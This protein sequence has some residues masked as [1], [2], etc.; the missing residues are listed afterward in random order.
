MTTSNPATR[1]NP[2]RP[3]GSNARER[4]GKRNGLGQ[5]AVRDHQRGRALGQQRRHGTAGSA[6]R[7]QH[8]HAL[9][10]D[11][12]AKVE[13]DV[14]QQADPVEIVRLDPVALEPQAIDGAGL[15]RPVVQNRRVGKR[16]ELERRRHVEATAPASAEGV[17]RIG[18]ALEWALDRVVCDGL[19]GR[20]GERSVDG[21]RFRLADRVADYRIMVGH[22][23]G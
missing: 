3:Q 21:G 4:L 20:F 2:S 23:A 12:R 16:I 7:A 18:E 13:C 9:A 6:A 14:P 17:D 5:A 19:P 22:A 11:R 15:P 8:Q 1:S 10:R